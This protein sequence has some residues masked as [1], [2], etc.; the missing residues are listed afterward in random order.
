MRSACNYI[1]NQ[2][3]A[4][5]NYNEIENNTDMQQP[6]NGGKPFDQGPSTAICMEE[7]TFHNIPTDFISSQQVILAL[8]FY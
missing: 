8:G 7:A 1:F 2:K 4:I 3:E 5:E 6:P